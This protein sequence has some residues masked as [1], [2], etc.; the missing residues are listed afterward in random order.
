MEGDC[1]IMDGDWSIM[2]GNWSM[3][4]DNFSTMEGDWSTMEGN[5]SI[6]DGDWLTKIT[7]DFKNLSQ[8]HII[9]PTVHTLVLLSHIQ[10][11]YYSIYV[12]IL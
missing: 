1:S 6:M 4:E 8:K 9:G 12:H 5:W 11:T 2:E 10:R 3:M 7:V